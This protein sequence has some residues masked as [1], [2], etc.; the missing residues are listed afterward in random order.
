MRCEAVRTISLPAGLHR[1]RLIGLELIALQVLGSGAHPKGGFISKIVDACG[2]DEKQAGSLL[3]AAG[4][5][6]MKVIRE[7]KK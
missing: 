3:A 6:Y 2:V 7:N 1:P 5:D 4:G